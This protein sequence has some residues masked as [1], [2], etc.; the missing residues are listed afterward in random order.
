MASIVPLNPQ[1]GG[2]PAGAGYLIF[3]NLV[4]ATELDSDEEDQEYYGAG[5]ENDLSLIGITTSP[6]LPPPDHDPI[7]HNDVGVHVSGVTVKPV[8]VEDSLWGDPLEN[9]NKKLKKEDDVPL[10]ECHGKVCSR[11]ICRVYEKQ[12]R[13]HRKFKDSHK[14]QG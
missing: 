2:G 10:C 8:A 6:A 3:P 11:G 7:D 4:A 1:Q 9:M 13:E 14:S 5:L 12:L